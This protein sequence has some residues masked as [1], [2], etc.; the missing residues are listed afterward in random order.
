VKIAVPHVRHVAHFFKI[1]A[2]LPVE[3]DDLPEVAANPAL[4]G[5]MLAVEIAAED[6][7]KSARVSAKKRGVR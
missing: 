7:S 4:Q 1:D 3:F 6:F 5:N 2:S